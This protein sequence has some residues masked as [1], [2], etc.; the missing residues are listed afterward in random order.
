MQL[1]TDINSLVLSKESQL[2]IGIDPPVTLPIEDRISMALELVDKTWDLAVAY[3]LNR[4]FFLGA[5]TEQMEEINQ[6]IHKHPAISI[7]DH[8][9]SD[10]GSSNLAALIAISEEGFDMLTVSPFPGNAE[11]TSTE[12]SKLGLEIILLTIMSNPEAKY[13]VEGSPAPYEKWASDAQ[14]FASGMVIGTTNHI[15]ESHLRRV[16]EI[17]PDPFVLAPGLG[18]QGGKPE[19]LQKIFGEKVIFTVS[20]GI[21]HAKDWREASEKYRELSIGK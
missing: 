15:K 2:C 11:Q 1:K 7:M 6:R 5:T 17:A 18:S 4:Q 21:M 19:L 13:L 3:K 12:A 14:K 10:V 16:K 20:R 9:L 8:K